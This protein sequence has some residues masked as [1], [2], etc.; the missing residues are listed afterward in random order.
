M[1][2]LSPVPLAVLEAPV[3]AP[4]AAPDATAPDLPEDATNFPAPVVAVAEVNMPLPRL[5]P[6][7]LDT[8]FAASCCCSAFMIE[9]TSMASSVSRIELKTVTS[10][11][12]RLSVRWETSPGETFRIP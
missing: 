11:L 7:P 2:E 8:R 4:A 3:A 12:V 6:I 1:S 10:R 5:T 9:L